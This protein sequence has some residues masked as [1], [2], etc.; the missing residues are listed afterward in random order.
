MCFGL[1][2]RLAY[3]LAL[4][5]SFALI[6]GCGSGAVSADSNPAVPLAISPT[7]A[8]A[9][10]GVPLTLTVSGGG[11][12]APYQFD[13]SDSQIAPVPAAPQQANSVSIM[14]N[15]VTG[16]QNVTIRVRDQSAQTASAI[17]TVQ[18]N[19][20][21]GDITVTGTAASATGIANCS[22]V[23]AVCAGQTGLVTVSLTQF[24]APAAGRSVRFEAAQGNYR[25][26][27]DQAQTQFAQSIVV[28]TDNQGKAIAILRA[29]QGSFQNAVIR[30][31]DVSS[32]AFRTASFFIRQATVAGAEYSLVPS[33]F[34]ATGFYKAECPGGLVDFLIF[35]GTPPF[36]IRSTLPA[37]SVTPTT[38]ANDSPSRFTVGYSASSCGT[39]GYIATFTVTDSRAQ[40]IQAS[41]TVRPG[42]EDRPVPPTPTAPSPTLSLSATSISLPCS[43][44]AGS[45][46]QIIA[47]V[48]NAGTSAS[49]ITAAVTT[50]VSP[51]SG[52]I[53]T[54]TGNVVTVTRSNSPANTLSATPATVVI[55]AGAAGTQSVSVM[56]P[57]TCP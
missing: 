31:T 45:S 15:T 48:A 8:T 33:G 34:I 7:T 38:T 56:T 24:G 6:G 21:A 9:Y 16:A 5:A 43:A 22:I 44:A 3:F 54:V 40:T 2:R 12:R 30:A 25:F 18:P 35:G 1:F 23:G 49:T 42:T 10:S 4:T 47:T 29:D 26:P 36:T 20:V 19:F 53:A 50:G 32:G 11:A 46:A 17:L 14:P 57:L 52:L 39:D 27:T 37:I 13:S 55:G 28:T 51:S 41:L